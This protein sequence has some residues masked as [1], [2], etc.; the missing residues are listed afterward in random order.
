MPNCKSLTFGITLAA[1]VILGLQSHAWAQ[2]SPP[3]TSARAAIA[4]LF[5]TYEIVQH[6]RII[7]PDIAL[8]DGTWSIGGVHDAGGK[9]HD[10]SGI[11]TAV[12][13]RTNSVWKL[14]AL[15]EQSS[16]KSVSPR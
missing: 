8:T 7:S 16:G 2:Q 12:I 6:V 9:T 13:V 4:Q 3:T 14:A 15:R 5:T 10:E 1:T 11:F